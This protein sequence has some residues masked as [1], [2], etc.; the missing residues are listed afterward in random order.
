MNTVTE[1]LRSDIVSA[2]ILVATPFIFALKRASGFYFG[3]SDPAFD[4]V[5]FWKPIT[6]AVLSGSP[7]YLD[8]TADNK[9]PLFLLVN[10]FTGLFDHQAVV[11]VL[12]VGL[13]NG[14]AAVLLWRFLGQCGRRE[15][16]LIAAILFLVFVP[17]FDAELIQA[18][19]FA[20]AFILLALVSDRP[21][22][23]GV[24]IAIAGLFYQYAVLVVPAVLLVQLYRTGT[25]T[26]RWGALYVCGGLLTVVVVFVTVGVVW[27]PE[28]ALAGLYWS[29]GIPT[30][31][32]SAPLYSSVT[33]APGAY[34]GGL[35]LLH[36]PDRWAAYG[37]NILLN[38][39]PL[40]LPIG[41][42][43]GADPW[44]F[45]T[46]EIQ[47]LALAFAASLP[48]LIRTYLDYTV[49]A[50]P[51]ICSLAALGFERLL[52]SSQA[53]FLGI[54]HITE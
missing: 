40:L 49:L 13:M 10:L 25:D 17:A 7:L 19:S 11:F 53:E 36:R 32:T 41:I 28:S 38:L 14:I 20:V 24:C 22:L 8:G 44:N 1:H 21:V 54:T 15:T 42:A 12:L 35:W 48:L 3:E 16:G 33:H 46:V 45:D 34:V 30:G 9:P 29:F 26:V 2:A 5:T 6:E 27:S 39:L 23:S 50:L 37:S 31:V 43:L 51:F 47:V 4:F 18:G 52:Q